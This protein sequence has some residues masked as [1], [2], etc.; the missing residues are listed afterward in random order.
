MTLYKN[1]KAMVCLSDGKSDFFVI[2]AEVLQRCIF[3]YNPAE[4]MF[5]E[6]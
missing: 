3:I 5:L 6:R 1:P 4:I 2:I